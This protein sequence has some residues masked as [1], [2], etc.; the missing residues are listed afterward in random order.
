M[1][2]PQLGKLAS[3]ACDLDVGI[4]KAQR[5]RMVAGG[6][7][8]VLPFGMRGPN[9]CGVRLW[10][11]ADT[12]SSPAVLVVGREQ[13]TLSS[14]LEH[15]VPFL[16]A[17]EASTLAVDNYN[18][19]DETAW[20]ELGALWQALGGSGDL[21]ALRE[22]LDTDEML[23]AWC[24]PGRDKKAVRRKGIAHLFAKVDPAPENERARRYGFYARSKD[25]APLPL[26]DAG[27][28]A[29]MVASDAFL[30]HHQGEDHKAAAEAAWA[31]LQLPA[32]LDIATG[33]PTEIVIPSDAAIRTVRPAAQTL[34]EAPPRKA[35][36]ADPLWPA[37]TRLADEGEAYAGAAHVAAGEKLAKA[38]QW[39]RA[40]HALMSASYFGAIEA[41]L[42]AA[43][44]VVKLM[45]RKDWDQVLADHQALL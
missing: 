11:A 9:P 22:T 30:V 19:L 15:L 6:T 39:D 5:A 42:A 21:A 23:A 4:T 29:G 26:P 1:E 31:L 40:L 13:K 37:M 45:G 34:V 3:A 32:G 20:K 7:W 35:W 14:R 41:S 38:K 27:C 16:L 8:W 33:G 18:K 36:T 12:G 10:P 28:F 44:K 43:R 25:Q 24:K 17:E 2:F